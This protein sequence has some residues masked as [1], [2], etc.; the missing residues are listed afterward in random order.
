M[1]GHVLSWRQIITIDKSEARNPKFETI[2]KKSK[3]SNYQNIHGS[4][5]GFENFGICTCLE[6]R[7]SNFEI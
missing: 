3:C 2:T 1:E 4:K 5:R 6:F 7:Y